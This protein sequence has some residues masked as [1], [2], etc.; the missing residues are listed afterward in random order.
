MQLSGKYLVILS[1]ALYAICG[2]VFAL[3]QWIK[4]EDTGVFRWYIEESNGFHFQLVQREAAQTRAFY[5]ARGFSTDAINH[6]AESC[7][8]HTTLANNSENHS[9]E[10]DLQSWEIEP[11]FSAG[12]NQSAVKMYSTDFWEDKWRKLFRIQLESRVASC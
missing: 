12:E 1:A 9:L 6:Y 7:V 8:F 11:I 3:N 2:N 10:V 4:K 5:I